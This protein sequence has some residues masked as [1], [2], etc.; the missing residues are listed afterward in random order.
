MKSTQIN[1]LSQDEFSSTPLGQISTWAL[2]IGRWIVVITELIV[3]VAFLARFKLDRDIANLSDEINQKQAIIKAYAPFEKKFRE[4]Q[5]R[6]QVVNQALTQQYNYNSI[7][8]EINK[9]LPNDV[10]LSSINLDNTELEIKATAL[11][12]PG[13]A[14]ME[15][16][17]KQ[18]PLFKRVT[19]T[20]VDI[21]GPDSGIEFQ[22]KAQL[23]T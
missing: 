14:G 17:L 22:I 16:T 20:R 9:S 15:A 6:L 12:E 21:S 23:A 13:M 3:I 4:T 8:G 1:L 18:S 10:V 19:L 5:T 7:L 11:T 2:S